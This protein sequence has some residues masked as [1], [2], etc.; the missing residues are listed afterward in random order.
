[1]T[2]RTDLVAKIAEL[3]ESIA[4]AGQMY[5][6]DFVMETDLTLPQITILYLL[7]SGPER[8]S[9]I[10]Q[11][12]GMA[13][14]NASNM[15]ERLVRKGLVER[16]SDPSDRRVALANLTDRGR[17]AV[18]AANR[19]NYLAIENVAAFLSTDELE[20]VARALQIL[21]RGVKRLEAAN[22]DSIAAQG[23]SR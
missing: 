23:A 4:T 17:E 13:R 9:G 5:P 8:I 16:V 20:L 11:A 6:R 19:G 2:A 1:M 22:E 21:D 18:E 7:T 3:S 12:Q 14:S 10:A 15:V